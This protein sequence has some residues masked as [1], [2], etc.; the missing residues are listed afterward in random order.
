MLF[1]LRLFAYR[2]LKPLQ[3]P[4]SRLIS[5]PRP[6]AFVG[7][8]SSFRLCRAIGQFGHRRVLIVTDVVLVKLGLVEPLRRALEEQG[9]AVAVHDG[10]TP[11]PTYPVL[12]AGH[13]AARAH[14]ADALLA[15]G[16]GSVIDA[17]KVIGAMYTSGKSP[18]R[19]VGTL[20]LGGA[21]LPLYVIPTTAGTGSEVTVAAVVTDPVAH[22]KAAVV[23]PRVVPVATALDPL[24]MRGMPPHITAA[25]GMDALTHAIEAYTNRWP[26]PD[27]GS[28]SIGAVKLVFANLPRAV[29]EGG[30]IEAREA[31][32]LAA[33]YAGLAFTKAYVG[34]VHAFSHKLGGVYGVPHG[35]ANAITLPYVLD[36]IQDA[37]YAQDRLAE[38]AIAIGA[39]R[40]GEPP[41]E[42][43]RRFTARV[44]ELNR[45]I[46]IPERMD[47]LAAGDVPMIAR[48]AMIEAHRDYPVARNMRL[49]EAEGLLRRMLPAEA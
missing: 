1:E 6:T 38:L 27:T 22:A 14:S 36:F 37:P 18:Q 34:Y 2:L 21:P 28:L 31:M 17:A 39:G 41:A 48:A 49:A 25:T 8:D 3:K 32:A 43:A 12:E 5:I 46:G 35:L 15:I 9:I 30:D 42:L 26:H 24:L 19:L 47:K 13:A 16:G 23:D 45:S 11:D 20:K 33:F 7:P 44:R 29:A 4:V 10:I 40:S